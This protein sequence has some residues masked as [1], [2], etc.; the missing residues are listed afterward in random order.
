MAGYEKECCGK[1]FST[2]I[3]RPDNV[4]VAGEVFSY[5]IRRPGLM[6]TDRSVSINH[7]AWRRCVACEGYETCYR[8]SVGRLLLEI[9][10]SV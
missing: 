7:G 3:G 1:M 10:L 9:A 5:Y 8:L 4:A 2:V 6:A